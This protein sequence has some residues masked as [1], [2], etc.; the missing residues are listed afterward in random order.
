[1]LN[2]LHEL[3]QALDHVGLLKNTTHP[4]IS[5]VVKETS[6]LIEIDQ[7]GAPRDLRFLSS[8]ETSRLWRHSKGNH[9]SFP[10]IRVQEPLLDQNESSKLEAI[11]WNKLALTK[12]RDFLAKLDFSALNPACTKIRISDWS[13][14]ELTFATTPPTELA[15]LEQLLRVFPREQDALPFV[16]LLAKMIAKKLETTNHEAELAAI[17]KLLVGEVD[18]RR[19]KYVASCMTYYDVYEADQFSNLVISP[20]TRQALVSELN[21]QEQRNKDEKNLIQSPLSGRWQ[22]AISDKYPNPNLPILGLTYLYSKKADTPCLTR[23]KRSGVE[24]YQIGRQ[25]AND[26]NNALAFLTSKERENKTWRRVSD[27]N[28]EKPNL[29]LVYLAEDP[30]NDA[31]LAQIMSDPLSYEEEEDRLEDLESVYVALC[32]QVLGSTEG[33]LRKNPKSE[34]SLLVF[35]SLDPGR[36]QVLYERSLPLY[37][38][39]NNLM[40]WQEAANNYPPIKTRFSDQDNLKLEAPGPNELIR[41]LKLSYF[42]LGRV[43]FG[44]QSSATLPEVYELYMPQADLTQADFPFVL[45]FLEKTL[46]A[47]GR[48]L[49][50]LGYLIRTNFAALTR[51][52]EKAV[53]KGASTAI[54]VISILLWHLEIRKENYMHSSPFNLG[55]LLSLAD[56]LHKQYCFV[57]RNKRD[58]AKGYPPRFIGGEILP[59]AL[60]DPVEG[61][62]RLDE[63]MRIYIDW[64]KTTNDGQVLGLLDLIGEAS[65]KIAG[66]PFPKS[67]GPEDRAQVFLG[68]LATV[69]SAKQNETEGEAMKDA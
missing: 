9:H 5:P 66:D 63:R 18:A 58:K 65:Y 43:K 25:E 38:V 14:G 16:G 31:L 50:D 1:M 51:N 41:L 28:G 60:E 53:L 52:E 24:A 27:C 12:K 57:V 8:E 35:E 6:L 17:K 22:E 68:Y 67:F 49:G 10:A 48:L 15:A 45:G 44:K 69:P 62:N 64:A 32:G 39:E 21:A 19:G 37:Q 61:L 13:L 3:S 7:K 40:I 20:V 4:N 26:M 23:Y 46:T 55:Q 29:L 54:S 2:E 11:E 34:V 42:G 36:K 56:G 30:A 59:I 33:L 47:T